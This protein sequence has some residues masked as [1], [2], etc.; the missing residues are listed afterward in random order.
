MPE[1]LFS[2]MVTPSVAGAAVNALSSSRSIKRLDARAD[3]IRMKTAIYVLMELLDLKIILP[4]VCP[5]SNGPK[6]VFLKRPHR[7]D[8]LS[9]KNPVF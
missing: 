3:N 8:V 4:M 2:N 1:N 7:Q 9:L 5:E 6:E